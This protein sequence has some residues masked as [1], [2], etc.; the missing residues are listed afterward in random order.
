MKMVV[1]I[2]SNTERKIQD[3]KLSRYACYLIVLNYDHRKEMI[4]L[5]KTYFAVQTR[6]Q[7]LMERDYESLTEDEK[8]FYQRSL[9]RN[10]NQS[11]NIAARNVDVKNF[12]RFHNFGYKG[13]YNGETIKN[14][15]EYYLRIF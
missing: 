15:L 7:E 8:R 2:G 6:K 12:D 10:G 3:Y 9:T 13:L 5:A 4:A 11:L 14:K 1:N